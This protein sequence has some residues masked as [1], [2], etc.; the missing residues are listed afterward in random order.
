MGGGPAGLYFAVLAKQTDPRHEIDVYER[1]RPDDTFG[2]GV[3]FSDNTMGFLSEQDRRS[4]PEITDASMRWDPF[5]VMHG[6]KVMRCGG[7][8]FSAIGRKKLLEILQRQAS[9]LGVRLHFEQPVDGQEALAGHDLVVASDGV[10]SGLRERL[11]EHLEPTVEVGPTRFTWLGTTKG[12]DSLTFFFERSEHGVFGAHIYPYLPDRSTFIVETDDATWRRAGMDGFSEED[13]ISYCERLFAGRLEG[14][15]L[16]SNRSLW[17]PFRTLTCRRWYHGNLVLIG[18]AAHTAH[19]S[20]GSGTKMAME[21]ALALSQ[22]LERFRPDVGAALAAYQEERKPRVEHIQRMAATSLDWWANFRHYVDLPAEQFAFHFLTRSQFRYDTLRPRDPGFLAQVEAASS[23]G[24]VRERVVELSDP[25]PV[26]DEGRVTPA[27]RGLAD[28]AGRGVG[29]ILTH[30]GPRGATMPRECGLD[31]PLREGAW[32]LLSASAVAYAPGGQVPREATRADMERVCLDFA[33]AAAEAAR[34]GFPLLQLDCAQGGLLASFISPLTNLRA[35]QY[36]GTPENRLRFPLEVLD[37][38]RAAWPADRRLLVAFSATDWASGG[39][40]VPDAFGAARAF[41][42][43]GADLVTVLGGQTV[44]GSTPAY[45]PCHQMLIAGKI[46]NEA[47][48]PVV[49]Q[50]GIADPDDLKT[51]LLS[52]R[53]DYCVLDVVR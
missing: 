50:G 39:L 41:R 7:V 47:G 21:D 16:L 51:V 32:L 33:A 10:N 4:Y 53:A 49:A 44:W 22:S 3:V 14:H 38:V 12:F 13:T 17:A 31:R 20:V 35:D 36:G 25:I 2:F 28:W 1:N 19:F 37:A 43:H 48:V 52:G 23:L 8:G 15:R 34:L 26:S 40:S 46:R 29:A 9:E 11:A 45:V 24:D 42:D 30:A 18:D 27:D 5:T 6:G